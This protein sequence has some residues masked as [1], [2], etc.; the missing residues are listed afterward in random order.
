MLN[1]K[2]LSLQL[3][4]GFEHRASYIASLVGESLTT[5]R[6]VANIQRDELSIGPVQ[7]SGNESDQEIAEMIA[8]QISSELGRNQ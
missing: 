3:P 4:R 6:P 2:R 8:Q 5:Y 1:I 7:I